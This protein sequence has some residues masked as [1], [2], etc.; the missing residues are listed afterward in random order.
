M[1]K[2]FTFF[3]LIGFIGA[4]SAPISRQQA[5]IIAGA[6][7]SDAVEYL[8]SEARHAKGATDY[9]PYY[10]FNSRE[11]SGFVIV[12]GDDAMPAVL[13]KVDNGAF[14]EQAAPPQLKSLLFHYSEV[15]DALRDR[16]QPSRREARKAKT[17]ILRTTALYG[18]TEPYNAYC[19]EGTLVGCEATAIATLMKY[20]QYPQQGTGSHYYEWNGRT[21]GMDFNFN[22]NWGRMLDD[23]S[24][25]YTDAQADAVAKLMYAVGVVVNMDYG[26]D[27]SSAYSED[28]PK[29]AKYFKYAGNP[30]Y[31][32]RANVI[33]D[34]M[35]E[36]LIDYELD[37]NGPVLYSGRAEDWT[38]GHMFL[39]DGRDEEG[40]Y[41]VNWGWTG[42]ANG[43]FYL[44]GLMPEE[45]MEG[46]DFR[47]HQELIYGVVPDGSYPFQPISTMNWIGGRGLVMNSTKIENG[48]VYDYCITSLRNG[49][50]VP[51]EGEIGILLVD[52]DYKIKNYL[53][54]L[55]F[56]LNPGYYYRRFIFTNWRSEVT[57]DATDRVV[58]A[59]RLKDADSWTMVQNGYLAPT[60]I[61]AVDFQPEYAEVEWQLGSGLKL[62]SC[63]PDTKYAQKGFPIWFSFD[64]NSGPEE[65]KVTI[66]GYE[67][68]P[69]ID[70]YGYYE[71]SV[72]SADKYVV[73][74]GT[75]EEVDGIEY[76]APE[77]SSAS[78]KAFDIH[79][80][81]VSPDP[82]N[83]GI[84]IIDGKKILK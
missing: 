48:G 22:L 23:Y 21:I 25:S 32:P 26:E 70:K 9:R 2:I 11:D 46:Y 74:A 44:T 84:Y 5:A 59:Y 81:P 72:I 75:P 57:A 47:Y 42:Y 69:S 35:W 67:Y 71:E 31:I 16:P 12:S 77:G 58:A 51:H 27:G 80:R 28:V 10:I 4:S 62:A 73:V 50:D 52:K 79:G 49:D 15:Y 24:G 30:Q 37:T 13:A 36:R 82:F 7:I 19:P 53:A 39:L 56:Q 54:R 18:Q 60:S 1:K 34:E 3:A 14:D 38:G 43:Y 20:H 33:S 64:Q 40:R 76:V 17:P 29:I 61:S 68:T 45:D 78:G 65:I 83:K 41:H 55:D 8:P 6:E 63:Y 66:N